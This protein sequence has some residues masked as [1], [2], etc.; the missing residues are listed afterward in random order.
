MSMIEE[1]LGIQIVRRGNRLVLTGADSQREAGR[2]ALD[3]LYH[4]LELG[5]ALEAGDLDDAVRRSVPTAAVLPLTHSDD[6]IKTRK[7][8][9][10]PR[11]PGQRDFVQKLRANHLVFGIGPAGTGKTY[12]AV[13]LAV[14]MLMDGLVDRIVLSRPAVTAGERLGFLPGDMKEKV[15][16]FMQPLYDALR[17]FLY[18]KMLNNYLEQGKIEIAPVAFVRG[19]TLSEA[20]VILDEAQN[21]TRMQMKMFLTRLGPGSRMAVTGDVTQIDLPPGTTSGLIEAQKVLSGVQGIAFTEFRSSEI[22]RH[23]LVAR[24][25]NAYQRD[26]DV[27]DS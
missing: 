21:A 7:R 13:A 15:D 25:V 11:S 17:S 4:L 19:R 5:R 23:G 27:R 10:E 14:S 3:Y 2:R 20:F 24:I 22:V 16:P 12:L 9:V 8:V 26:V 18:Q 6:E 1:A